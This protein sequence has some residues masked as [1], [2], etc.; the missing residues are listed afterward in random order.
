MRVKVNRFLDEYTGK[1]NVAGVFATSTKVGGVNIAC[2]NA[3]GYMY[4]LP[5]DVV[6]EI[7]KK[8]GKQITLTGPEWQAFNLVPGGEI[9]AED[10]EKLISS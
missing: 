1:C 3:V 5:I 7:A 6:I 10:L 4:D 9:P 8:Y 2:E